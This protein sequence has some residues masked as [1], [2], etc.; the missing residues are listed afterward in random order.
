M[1]T[2]PVAA[3]QNM[4]DKQVVFVTTGKP[5]VFI[6][7]PVRLGSENQGVFLVLE[8]LNVGDKIATEGSF[9]LRAEFL[10]QNLEH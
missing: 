9:L 8:G 1:S 2:I 6:V 10:K 7:R 5:N 3:V 4:N